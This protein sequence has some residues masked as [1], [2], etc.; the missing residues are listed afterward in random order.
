VGVAF[1]K[2]FMSMMI[3]Y[4][5]ISAINENI[6]DVVVTLFASFIDVVNCAVPLMLW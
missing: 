2:I 5:F 3:P 1:I 6:F 4:S